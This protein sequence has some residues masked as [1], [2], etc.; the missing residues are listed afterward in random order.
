MI[1]ITYDRENMAVSVVGH[2]GADVYGKDIVCAGVSALV[3]TLGAAVNRLDMRG[4]LEECRVQ[5]CPGEAAVQC[6][7]QGGFECLVRT[8]LDSL[9]L[10]LELLAEE[11]PERIEM[12]FACG[13]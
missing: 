10:G 12:R 8:V 4:V 1:Q 9:V 7:A 11:Y 2:A 5:L 3:C 6:K 13:K